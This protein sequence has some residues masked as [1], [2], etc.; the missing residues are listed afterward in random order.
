M[1]PSV[2]VRS[3]QLPSVLVRKASN[4]AYGRGKQWQQALGLLTDG[5]Q[6]LGPSSNNPDLVPHV[7]TYNAAISAC[8]K[9]GQWQQALSLLAVIQNADLMPKVITYN[10]SISA[11]AKY[12]AAISACEKGEQ[13]RLWKR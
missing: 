11:C 12:S 6:A 13:W 5:Q 9:G 2:P 10:A 7:V 8:E 1:L 4:G 3:T